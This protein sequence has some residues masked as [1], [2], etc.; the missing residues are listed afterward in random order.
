M[1]RRE[2]PAKVKV[3]AFQRANGH[4][5]KCGTYIIAGAQYD[6]RI[7]DALGGEPTL[8]NC[9]CLCAKC[10]RSKTSTVDVPMIAKAKRIE[11]KRVGAK[12]SK[13]PLPGSRATRWKRKIDGSVV[14]RDT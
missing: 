9:V 3:A 2:F 5:E 4:C 10:H 12:K 7:P 13:N 14:R 1:S 8:E 11:A 6:H